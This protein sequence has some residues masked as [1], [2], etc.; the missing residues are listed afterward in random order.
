MSSKDVITEMPLDVLMATWRP[1][2]TD[3]REEWTWAMESDQLWSDDQG[4]MDMLATSI[5]ESGITK[6]VM[7][8]HDGRVW[9]GHHRICVA[10]TLGLKSVPFEFMPKDVDV[11]PVLGVENGSCLACEAPQWSNIFNG[12]CWNCGSGH[13]TM[14]GPVSGAI[15]IKIERDRQIGAEGWS[16]EHDAEHIH[17]ELLKAADCY[18]W[19]G[20]VAHSH[21]MNSR[22]DPLDV[23]RLPP[24][25]DSH[26]W[27]WDVRYW[28]PEVDPIKNLTKAGALIAAEIDRINALRSN[29]ESET[30]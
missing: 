4:R 3:A 12:R 28:K 21:E 25:H 9:D 17:H 30:N 16:A 23:I 8:G 5:Q 22:Y 26:F 14:E 27:P 20:L 10:E 6:P 13:V 19:A 2:S 7:L 24:E 11:A 1:G 18:M 29:S 15:L